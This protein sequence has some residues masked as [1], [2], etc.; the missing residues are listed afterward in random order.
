MIKQVPYW[1]GECPPAA[2]EAS[3]LP[4]NCD[5]AIVGGGYAGL[6]AAIELARGGAKVVV[7]EADAFGFNASGRNS[8]GV[9]FG[10]DFAKVARWAKWTGRGAPDVKAIARGALDSTEFIARFIA[11][12]G[13]DCDFQMG[14]RLSCAPTPRHYDE[15]CR[16][17]D[18]INKLFDA[19]AYVVAR[20]DQHQEIG[21]DRFHGLTVIPKSA[22]LSPARYLHGLLKLA[23]D[24]GASLHA[25]TRVTGIFRSEIKT[26]RGDT[27]AS[28]IVL[29]VN[30]FS[31]GLPAGDVGRRV[32]PVKS[33]ILVTEPLD[34]ARAGRLIP[35]RRSGADMRRLLAYFRLT[36]DGTRFLYGSRASTEEALY[37]RMVRTFPL[38]AGVKIDYSWN[39][40]VAFSFDALP[41]MG[42]K[43]GFH[44][45]AGCNGNGVAM[46][47]YLGNRTGRKILD[48]GKPN[49]AF[50]RDDFPTVP[51]YAGTPWFLPVVMAGYRAMDY[52]DELRT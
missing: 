48:G 18:G 13:I 42:Q 19:G 9:S 44:Y 11:D 15:M 40:K 14:G 28:H 17:V 33:H 31:A 52:M 6:S 10:I 47:S 26:T 39:C 49:C 20:K 16:K 38:L 27:K 41:H 35:K 3:Q 23:R 34:A 8:G 12:N 1:W 46:M 25:N 30:A 51:L 43:D 22:Q 5:V 21:S 37:A 24:A 45:I 29:A 32:V 50:D 4:A 7:L 36:P 2:P